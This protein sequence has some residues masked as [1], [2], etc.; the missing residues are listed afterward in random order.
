MSWALIVWL[1]KRGKDK[2]GK[3]KRKKEFWS[4]RSLGVVVTYLI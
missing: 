2:E 1:S 4:V 3:K